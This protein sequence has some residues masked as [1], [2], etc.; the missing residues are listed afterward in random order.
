M[1]LACVKPKHLVYL[2]ELWTIR[3]LDGHARQQSEQSGHPSLARLAGG[4]VSKILASCPLRPHK[5]E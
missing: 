3:L 4:T 1:A 2:E 5:I